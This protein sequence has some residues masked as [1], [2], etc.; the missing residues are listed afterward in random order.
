MNVNNRSIDDP[1][2]G[3]AWKIY[4]T[5]GNQLIKL[6]DFEKFLIALTFFLLLLLRIFWFRQARKKAV[7]LDCELTTP[8]DYTLMI[9]G[10]PRD[11]TE[12]EVRNTFENYSLSK[13]GLSS[14]NNRV[15]R[16]NFAYYI[17]D[18]IRIARL[19]NDSLKIMFKEKRRNE[20][21]KILIKEEEAK[22]KE[23][24]A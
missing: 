6:Y 23:Y 7:D 21:D 22:V 19:K 10:L 1:Y 12:K 4:H 9:T 20:P 24:D 15:Y 8:K 14:K 11:V 2:C 17:G 5:M 3:D 18:F 13:R 16:V